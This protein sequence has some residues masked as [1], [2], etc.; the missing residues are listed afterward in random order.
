[1]RSGSRRTFALQS[2]VSIEN[3]SKSFGLF[4]AVNDVS[5][6]IGKGE[7]FSLLGPSG[8][9]KSTLLRMIAGF[10]TP[11]SGV[12]RLD[13]EEV[14]EVPA[15]RRPTNMMFQSYALFPHLSVGKNIAFGLQ[16]DRLA[17]SEIRQRVSEVAE[18]LQLTALL[19]RKQQQLSGGQRQRVALARALVKR[20][21]VLLLDEPLGALDKNLRTETQH[22]LVRLQRELGLTFIIVTHDQHE[23]MTVSSRIAI[24]RQGKVLQIGSPAEVYETPVSRYVAKFLGEANVF[25][26]GA[27]IRSGNELKVESAEAGGSVLAT[28]SDHI[29]TN[30]RYW[31]SVRPE[32]VE[33]NKQGSG[34]EGVVEQFSYA[35]SGRHYRVRLKSGATLDALRVNLGAEDDLS[36]GDTVFAS[37]MPQAARLLAD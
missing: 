5:V 17:R 16:Q 27:A 37:W 15:H 26:G 23:A 3:L 4:S 21:K 36:V 35:G 10:E 33:L 1:M 24:M 34:L 31:V 9:G 6:G 30:A 8:C 25:E 11:T 28:A 29:S 22:E 7:F 20:P 12:V 32:R 2:Y 14:T 18:K 13:G 19:D